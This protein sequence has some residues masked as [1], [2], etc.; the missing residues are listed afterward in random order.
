MEDMIVHFQACDRIWIPGST[1]QSRLLNGE[2]EEKG[3]GGTSKRGQVTG[4][5]WKPEHLS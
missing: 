2:E 4:Y 1:E 5:L 3:G